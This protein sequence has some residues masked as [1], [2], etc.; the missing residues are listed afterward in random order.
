MTT[1]PNSKTTVV[2]YIITIAIACTMVGP[3]TLSELP[4]LHPGLFSLALSWCSAR[5]CCC[6]HCARLQTHTQLPCKL[7]HVLRQTLCVMILASVSRLFLVQCK[8]WLLMMLLAFLTH[9]TT[10]VKLIIT[11]STLEPE[12]M[13]RQMENH[14]A[15]CACARRRGQAP[16]CRASRGGGSQGKGGGIEGA[17]EGQFFFCRCSIHPVRFGG[18]GGP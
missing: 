1:F 13:S 15:P 12:H 9:T 2:L 14:P 5:A 16:P 18:F 11:G 8:G 17:S 3:I 4:W 10:L 6:C 7:D